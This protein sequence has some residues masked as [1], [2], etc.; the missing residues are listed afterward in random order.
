MQK[1]TFENL[2]STNT[3]LNASNLNTLQ[4]NVEN[5]INDIVNVIYP[6]GSIYISVNNT[7]PSTLFGGTWEQIQDRFLLGAGDTYTAGDTGGNMPQLVDDLGLTAGSFGGITSGGDYSKRI[8]ASSSTL[9]NEQA[10]WNK[11]TNY[12]YDGLPPYLTVYMWK[13]T[14]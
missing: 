9:T 2:P 4:N 7:N 3:P 1:I 13:R 12:N 5:A 6:V 8:V 14:A 10:Y 11:F